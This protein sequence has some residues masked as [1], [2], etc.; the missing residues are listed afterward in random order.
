MASAALL[1]PALP[2][3]HTA[4]PGFC[5]TSWPSP[6]AVLH[7]PCSLPALDVGTSVR[8][9]RVCHQTW[10]SWRRLRAHR[11]A[12]FQGQ[13]CFAHTSIFWRFASLRALLCSSSFLYIV[14]TQMLSLRCCF[15]NL[16]LLL[17]LGHWPETSLPKAATSHLWPPCHSSLVGNL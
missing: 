2:T 10:P 12:S 17:L 7:G 5:D 15:Q 11:L 14:L 16:F 3:Y 1:A 13:E 9:T 4:S 6:V 8:L